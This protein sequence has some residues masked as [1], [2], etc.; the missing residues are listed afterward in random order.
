[1]FAP[2]TAFATVCQ[3]M[4]LSEIGTETRQIGRHILIAG[5]ALSLA[6]C[7]GMNLDEDSAVGSH[8]SQPPQGVPLPKAEEVGDITIAGQNF[9]HAIMD[10]PAVSGASVP[11]LVQFNGVTSIIDQP[12]DTEPYTEL[13]RD[14][15]L[16]LTREKLRFLEHTLPPYVPGKKHKKSEDTQPVQNISNPDYEILAEMRGHATADFYRIQIE[17]VDAH[18]HQVLYSGLYHI[19]PEAGEQPAPEPAANNYQQAPPPSDNRPPVPESTV[20]D[21]AQPTT[22]M[23]SA[24]APL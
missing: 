2:R 6:A 3:N 17:F 9:A 18:S 12:I 10:L 24:N 7:A 16:L 13:L 19:R 20:P 1:M 23:P 14:R 8:L 15:L 4:T 5:C 22:R 11:P 21:T